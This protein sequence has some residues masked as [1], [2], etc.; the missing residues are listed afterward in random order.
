MDAA[1]TPITPRSDLAPAG[2]LVDTL[3]AFGSRVDQLLPSGCPAYVRLFHRPDQG[4]PAPDDD[5]TWA[6]TARRYDTVL[7]PE[8][9]WRALTRGGEARSN[10]LE[11]SLDRLSLAR[12]ARHVGH[13]TTTPDRYY[14]ALWEGYGTLP[15]SWLALPRVELPGRNYLLFGPTPADAVNAYA[16]EFAVAGWEGQSRSPDGIRDLLLARQGLR[17]PSDQ[18]RAAAS[19]EFARSMRE[20]GASQ[21]PT[22][23]W[24]EDRAWIVLSEIDFDSTL[25]GC[26]LALRDD[27]LADPDLEC[28]EVTP[29]TSLAHDADRVNGG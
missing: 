15:D 8:A 16:V 10:P 6:A 18:E 3:T 9:Q 25:I 24:P 27:L 21:S 11:G 26:S 5:A 7:H 20:Q 23:W 28:L 17:A 22:L 13:H 12:L 2:W 14:L 29:T 4:N 1:P 19:A